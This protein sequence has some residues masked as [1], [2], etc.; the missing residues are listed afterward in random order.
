MMMS[1]YFFGLST[2]NAPMRRTR[3]ASS[4]SLSTSSGYRR[5]VAGAFAIF[6]DGARK[7]VELM[8]FT[9]EKLLLRIRQNRNSITEQFSL[10]NS[11][12]WSHSLRKK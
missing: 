7:W 9:R 10:A 4:L 5:M 12:M 1:A 2:V 11:L 6:S 8:E 3:G